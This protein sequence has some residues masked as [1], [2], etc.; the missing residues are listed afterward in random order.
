MRIRNIVTIQLIIL[1]IVLCGTAASSDFFRSPEEYSRS[2]KHFS[3][4]A[5]SASSHTGD[6]D[7]LYDLSWA[8]YEEGMN[9]DALRY[10]RKAL[11]QKPNMAFLNARA[12]DIFLA[13]GNTDSAAVYYEAA[14]NNEYEYIEAWEKLVALKPEYYANL[15]LLYAEKIEE[16]S[17]AGL[18]ENGEH[19]LSLYIERFPE[20]DYTDECRT[21][22]QRIQLRRRQKES[23]QALDDNI[24]TVQAEEA[25]RKSEQKAD[26]ENF[27]TEKP[28]I[29]GFGFFSVVLSDDHD[30]LAKHPDEVIDD[31]LSMKIYAANL[32]EFAI[33]GGYVMGPLFLR[34]QFHFGSTSSGKNYFLRDP[35]KWSYDYD[36][37]SSSSPWDSVLTDST[38][39]T[40]DDVRPKVHAIKTLRFSVAADYN[41]YYMNPLLLYVGGNADI[42]TATLDDSPENN[43]DRITLAGA[44]IGGGVMLRFSD[45]LF[46]LSYRR[47]VVGSSAGGNIALMGIYKF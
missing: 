13:M 42:G 43:F 3:G 14:L 38:I 41:F 29:V 24:R 11:E 9:D 2:G 15:G 27:R 40:K 25:H 1:F 35:V 19:Y 36:I 23:R 17:D 16:H 18:L 22:L 8:Y 47:N 44:G 20:G 31:T 4:L 32:N 46:D 5:P 6:P 12:G 21:A 30:F 45:F 33:A 28:W 34:G 39:S 10:I 7:W 37:D 26:R